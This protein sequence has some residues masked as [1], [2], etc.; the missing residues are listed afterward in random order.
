MEDLQT[1]RRRSARAIT[2]LALLGILVGLATVSSAA[3][4]TSDRQDERPS[5]SLRATARSTLYRGQATT[6]TVR[7]RFSSDTSDPVALRV[8]GLPAGVTATVVSRNAPPSSVT[9]TN[10][11]ATLI[12]SGSRTV[13]LGSYAITIRGSSGGVTRST[14]SVLRARRLP[15]SH[16]LLRVS[17]GSVAT[18]APATATYTISIPRTRF[19]DP[20][21]FCIGSILPAGVSV[22]F[23]PDPTSGSSSTLTLRGD[24]TVLRGTF[25]FEISA[26][27][28]AGGTVQRTSC[29]PTTARR[30]VE[31]ARAGVRRFATGTT[32]TVVIGAATDGGGTPAPVGGFTISGDVTQPLHPGGS[33]LPIDLTFHN[34]TSTTIHVTDVTVRVTATS[35]GTA[36]PPG[37]FATTDFSYGTSGSG[38]VP[39]G[40]GQTVSLQ[41]AGVPLAVWP[42]IRMNDD[43][44]QDACQAATVSL[45]YTDGLGYSP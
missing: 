2:A 22:S 32:A 17:P 1:D 23:A 37:D 25:P 15:R 41:D 12:L 9:P 28:P 24:P 21:R 20:V 43:G 16:V 14:T 19:P 38:G 42:T 10:P 34:P 4:R 7:V 13:A 39:V 18:T 26:H 30:R 35:A 11:K 29:V 27:G 44:N 3:F 5:F 31:A 6:A 45:G 8:S 40:P 36:C 33:P